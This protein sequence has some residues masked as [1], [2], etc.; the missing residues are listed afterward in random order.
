MV[1]EG[2]GSAILDD[3]FAAIYCYI[4]RAARASQWSSAVIKGGSSSCCWLIFAI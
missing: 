1:N 4:Q 2:A 3:A